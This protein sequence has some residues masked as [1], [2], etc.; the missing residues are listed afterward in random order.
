M[1]WIVGIVV[2]LVIVVAVNMAMLVI[3]IQ[4]AD[5][6]DPTYATEAR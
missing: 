1:R 3:A 6:I 5:P 4:S 2:S